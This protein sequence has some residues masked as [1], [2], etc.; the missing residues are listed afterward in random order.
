MAEDRKRPKEEELQALIEDAKCPVCGNDHWYILQPELEKGQE[1]TSAVL[2]LR[3]GHPVLLNANLYV[4]SVC[5]FAR[6]HVPGL[7]GMK[8]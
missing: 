1:F 3:G 8:E 6:Q 2:G 7:L 4:C 5:G